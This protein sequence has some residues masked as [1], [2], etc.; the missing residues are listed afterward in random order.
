MVWEG[1]SCYSPKS[2]YEDVRHMEITDGKG[3]PGSSLRL[4]SSAIDK[5]NPCHEANRSASIRG[6]GERHREGK[7][8]TGYFETSGVE[9]FALGIWHSSKEKKA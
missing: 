8:E 1:G 7:A 6:W 3:V 9:R 5:H 2:S 4:L